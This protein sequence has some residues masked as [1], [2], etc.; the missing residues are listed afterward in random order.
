MKGRDRIQVK[1]PIKVTLDIEAYKNEV[2]FENILILGLK[3]W[4]LAYLQAWS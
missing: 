3:N 1:S 2:P 4:A